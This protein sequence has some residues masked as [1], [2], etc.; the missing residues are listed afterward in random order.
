MDTNP[1]K[2]SDR[3]RSRFMVRVPEI[4]RTKL[5]LLKEKTGKPMTALVQWALKLLLRGFGLWKEEDDKELE[6]EQAKLGETTEG[7]PT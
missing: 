6:R 4:F 5:Q 3:H 1:D 2:S 7:E